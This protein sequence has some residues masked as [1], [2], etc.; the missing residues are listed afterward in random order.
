MGLPTAFTLGPFAAASA[1]VFAHSQTPVSGTLLTLQAAQPDVPRRILLTYGSE[2]SA[3]TLV[4]TGTNAGG[5]PIQETLA[6]PASSSGSVY[7]TQDFLTLVSALPLGGGWTAAVTLGT[8]GIGSSPPKF[9]NYLWGPTQISISGVVSGT[10]TWGVEY[11]Y[12]DPS[13]SVQWWSHPNLAGLSS[14]ADGFID[15]PIVAW[16]AVI[17]AGT[18]S[19]QVSAI[20]GGMH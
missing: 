10:V 9:A 4:L 14:S 2:G 7:T 18:G 11:A 16:R 17:S 6:V 5:M 8:N 1:N 15:N 13:V 20:E 12:A 3:R 19:V